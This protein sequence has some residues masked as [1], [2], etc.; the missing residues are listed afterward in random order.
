MCGR[1]THLLS[2]RQIHDLYRLTAP[3]EPPRL[4]LRYNAC[5]TQELPVI[6]QGNGGRELRMMRWGLIPYWSKDGGKPYS[7]I[8]ARAESVRTKPAFR[9]P[10]RRR[11]CLV[12]VSGFF[13]WRPEGRYKQ[14]YYITLA[15]GPMT[16]AGLWDR[17]NGPQGPV[18]T[19][20]IVT[21]T[22]APEIAHLHD[23]MPVI[24]PQQAW[25]LWLD[26]DSPLE[27]VE[28]LLQPWTAGGFAFHPVSRAVNSPSNDVPGNI[29]RTEA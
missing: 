20:T 18:E 4:P 7:T 19:Y 23:R 25:D 22:A 27:L 28:Q 13:E 16:F 5:P 10:F 24:L 2:W 29:L 3:K 6:V 14:P 9:E 15:D 17:W 12:P 11:R 1:Y 26:P 8:N 21:T